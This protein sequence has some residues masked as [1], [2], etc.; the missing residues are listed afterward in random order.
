MAI[1][2]GTYEVLC[3]LD[4]GM[5]LDVHGNST[6]NKANVA[7]WSRNGSN[8]QKWAISTTGGIT[9]ILDAETG[10]SLDVNGAKAANGT[11]VFMYTRNS[12]TNQRWVIVEDGTQDVNGTAYPKVGIGALGGTTYM[13]DVTGGKTELNTN[14]EIWT[15]NG[16]ANQRFV[17]V[18]TE[19]Q[20]TGGD[21]TL[22][23][24]LP[25]PAR[26]SCGTTAGA[27]LGT[28]CAVGAATLLPS[29][30]CPEPLYQVR[31]RTR[32][33]AEG[34]DWLGEWS[35]WASI[36]DGSTAWDG[37]GAPG[38]SNCQPTA[39]GGAMWSPDGV[40]VDNTSGYDRTDV[41]F[42][43]RA[44]RAAWGASGS[45]AHG[46]ALTWQITSARPVTVS[47][48]SVT[49][50]PDGLVVAWESD[51]TR[52]GNAVT[53]T[54]PAWGS[55]SGTGP[56]TG[57]LTVPMSAISAMPAEGD[58]LDVALSLVTEDGLSAA[59]SAPCAVSYEGGHAGG[60]TLSATATGTL[61]TVTA[62]DAAASAWLVIDE[63]HG[64][65]YVALEGTSPWVVAPPLNVPW[66]VW[67]S[68][69]GSGGWSSTIATFPAV[70]DS[71]YHVTS[72]GMD[73][74]LGIYAAPGGPAEF[75]PS[76]SRAT[77][78]SEVMGRERSVVVAASTND[79]SWTIEGA[80]WGD[81]MAGVSALA[82]WAI[83]AGH[84]IFRAPGGFWS[85]A[86]VTGGSQDMTNRGWRRVELSLVGEVW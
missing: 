44:W 22:Y 5:A 78:S 38:A 51:C 18:P 12:G 1:A 2:D 19:W 61:A 36:A 45:P 56:G 6:A 62:S 80:A 37:F 69:E 35:D 50:A 7:I 25:T 29:W 83:H 23:A 14:V 33:R 79:V 20:A 34:A 55:W 70:E 74:D 86:C 67:A 16:G 76:W 59:H 49:I 72:P 21:R 10:K 8:A 9:T 46:G 84:V 60:L 15:S 4:T 75:R 52:D 17:L 71:G 27:P 58:V 82:D 11:N 43:A 48:L 28:T 81:D 77:H 53:V 63:G 3:S 31:Y 41:E 68:V 47:A 39:T 57:H 65:R 30:T 66:R 24:G 26:G 13:L 64:T 32:T 85:Q 40:A 42:C 73:R 54:C